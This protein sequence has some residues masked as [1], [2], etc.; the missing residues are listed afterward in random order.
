MLE[1]GRK[2]SQEHMEIRELE[3]ELEGERREA[4]TVASVFSK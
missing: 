1:L 4:E 2:I 3:R